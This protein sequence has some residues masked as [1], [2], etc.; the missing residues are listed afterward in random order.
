MVAPRDLSALLRTPLQRAAVVQDKSTRRSAVAIVIRPAAAGSQVLYILRTP[1]DSDPWSGQVAFPG[2]RRDPEDASDYEC[3]VREAREEVGL[4]LDDA[5][6]FELL[7]QLPPRPIFA[8]GGA[9]P[10]RCVVPFVFAQVASTTP[11][12]TL[13]PS[14]VA[15][16]C[17]AHE[18]AL[19]PAHVRYAI[20]KPYSP[21]PRAAERVVPPALRRALGLDRVSFPTIALDGFD[22]S[23]VQLGGDGVALALPAPRFKL[24]GMTLGMTSDLLALTGQA[25][26]NKPPAMPHNGLLRAAVKLGALDDAGR[27]GVGRFGAAGALLVVAAVAASRTIGARL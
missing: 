15:A 21:L 1:R 9:L 2:G 3:A 4:R 25:A 23:E 7:G 8:K 11:P 18:G 16:V 22:A 13:Q 17:W 26:L 12:L 24:W 6:N 19:A 27:F 5:R 14:E 10:G 20:E